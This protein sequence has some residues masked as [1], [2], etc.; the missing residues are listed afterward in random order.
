MSHGSEWL[1]SSPSPFSHSCRSANVTKCQTLGA[2]PAAIDH[3]SADPRV[4]FRFRSLY[5]REGRG[6][7]SFSINLERFF[8]VGVKPAT[9][10]G[11]G[12]AW[13]LSR[14]T[15]V[16]DNFLSRRNSIADDDDC[17]PRKSYLYAPRLQGLPKVPHFAV[18]GKTRKSL[19]LVENSRCPA[20]VD[21][22]A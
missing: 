13:K 22:F 11:N 4:N 12:G 8:S 14:A 1:N 3:R 15:P 7:S 19:S 20:R 9:S 5:F 2:V 10:S 21:E 16:A 18:S 17:Y 6:G